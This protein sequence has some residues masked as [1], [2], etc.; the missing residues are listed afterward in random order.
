MIIV[1]SFLFSD[2][3]ITI[4]LS[5]GIFW[6]DLL[7][8]KDRTNYHLKLTNAWKIRNIV[9]PLRRGRLCKGRH[10]ELFENTGFPLPDQVRHRPRGNDSKG[11]FMTYCETIGIG[12]NLNTG[13]TNVEVVDSTLE[14]SRRLSNQQNLP[15][16]LL[17]PLELAC[18]RKVP[19]VEG[20]FGFL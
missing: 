4:S 13:F 6:L 3:G 10:P 9:M 11:W 16:S 17:R 2:I 7:L 19:R 8:W 20:Q 5:P 1:K 12:N 15:L 18:Q 14:Q